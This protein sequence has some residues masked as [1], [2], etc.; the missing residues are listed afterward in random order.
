MLHWQ[1]SSEGKPKSFQQRKPIKMTIHI[2]RKT[3][4]ILAF[5]L[6]P[7]L[8]FA[9]QS[10]FNAR[11][12]NAFTQAEKLF[13]EKAYAAAQISFKKLSL[14]NNTSQE[15]KTNAAYYVAI[16][17]LQM[18]QIDADTQ[19]LNFTQ[20][21]P[22]S[23]K[24]ELA[25]L[26]AGNTFFK[27]N[28]LKT[29]LNWYQKINEENL[30]QEKQDELN[31]NRS[32]AYMMTE[33]LKEGKAGFMK[34]LSSPS[35]GAEANY[36]V[37]YIAYKQKDYATAE[38]YLTKASQEQSYEGEASY[39][40]LDINF[41]NGK[42]DKSIAIGKTLLTKAS[43]KDVSEIS[44]IIGES[45]FNLKKYNEAIPYLMAYKGKSGKWNNT[46]FYQLGYAY[47]Q[48]KD[49]PNAVKNFTKIISSVDAVA[50]N[51][52]Y[53]L[54]ECYLSLN[55]KSEAL[56]AFK[57]A[58]EMSFSAKI[59]E[60]A[61]LNYAK[62]SYEQGNPYKSVAL[63]LQDF[64]AAYPQSAYYKEINTLVVTSY[65]Y[66]QDYQGALNYL[67]KNRNLE[68]ISLS[69]D[70]SFYRG[71][72]LFNEQK[73]KQAYPF[74]NTAT[75]SNDAL[76]KVSAKYWKAETDDQLGNYKN[77]L[78]GFLAFKSDIRA[79]A[80]NEYERID[81]GIAYSYFKLKDYAKAATFFQ[82]FLK[83]AKGNNPLN[84]DANIRLGD[85]YFASKNYQNAINAYESVLKKKGIGSDY[86]L[87]QKG[88]SFGFIGQNDQK[89]SNLL[90]V[91]SQYP[92]SNLQDDALFQTASTYTLLKNNTKA[93]QTYDRLL[94]EHPKSSYIP[95]ALLR[96]GLLYY[97]DNKP[98]AALE[99]YKTIVKDYAATNEAKQAV[100]NARNV[101]VDIGQVDAY[102][103]WVKNLSFVNV[104]N[105]DL[106][107]TIYEAAENKFLANDNVKA[108][109]GFSKYLSSFPE[110]LHALQAHFY[111]AQAYMSS[112]ES[113]KA[114]THYQY[115]VSKNQSEFSEE[116]LNRLAQIYL[117]KENWTA[118][119]PLLSRLEQEA[120]YAQ[121]ILFAQSNLMK[122]YYQNNEFKKANDYA[123]K[124]LKNDKLATNVEFDAKIIIA[125]VAFKTN[126]L[127]TAENYY[128][129]IEAKASGEL[130]AEALYYSAYFKNKSKNYSGSNSIVQQLI[131]DYSSYKYWGVKSYVI[132][133][134]N[135]YALKDAYQ[136]TY[137]LE[138]IIKNFSQ[139][140]DVIAD[141]QKELNL[142]KEQEAKTNDSVNPK[143]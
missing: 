4:L 5:F 52:Y 37:G 33:Q 1:A 50:Q 107:N 10:E 58:S 29:A 92:T 25:L 93:H 117:E 3:S 81:Y 89:I 66:Q 85:C 101:Y 61:F 75:G 77:A 38:V 56:N 65:I 74:F 36:Y 39:S 68:N 27:N 45:Y 44:K 15:V 126:D 91:A 51:A 127:T 57:N 67:S 7:F 103:A 96:Q 48:Q 106:D 26:M 113:E 47:Y 84:D 49:Y 142:I 71:V 60:D 8:G 139:Y 141:A 132:M 76:I 104:T 120:N 83:G 28:E 109:D 9:Q 54:A 59:K 69:K 79:S 14:Q 95:S 43:A 112:N 134:K 40:L 135:Y 90:A 138:N 137:I 82:S 73:L 122:G 31:F 136:A 32:Y 133:A 115:V 18:N 110:G 123:E 22:Q 20:N 12:E 100:S 30:S 121:N 6:A 19:V 108:I 111:L 140:E 87:Y 124:V 72:Q 35:Y 16:C 97:N 53:H 62:L 42:F 41:K 23:P 11:P 80:I 114:T 17:A 131:A 70:V 24:K 119:M 13:T 116:S 129:E 125:R 118:A 86:A 105:A 55:Q 63:V 34:L 128:K 64:L 143:N 88:M 130:K 2:F 98:D 94:K 21:Y 78:E 46:D 99:K 102:A